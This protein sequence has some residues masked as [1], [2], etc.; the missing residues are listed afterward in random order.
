LAPFFRLSTLTEIDLTYLSYL[1]KWRSRR[2]RDDHENA[3]EETSA[4]LDSMPSYQN[5][6]DDL[7]S[8]VKNC[9]AKKV[10]IERNEMGRRV[11][12]EKM[13]RSCKI[14]ERGLPAHKSRLANVLI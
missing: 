12:E 2:R 7:G 4:I 6:A 1:Y 9:D 8:V 13:S 3:D 11:A 10:T 5:D 14:I